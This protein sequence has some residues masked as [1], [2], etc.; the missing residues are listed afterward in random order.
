[1]MAISWFALKGFNK[2]NVAEEWYDELETTRKW[3]LNY[4]FWY[5]DQAAS[6]MTANNFPSKIYCEPPFKNET[7]V[8]CL[9]QI[10]DI[11]SIFVW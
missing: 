6:L 1:M 8:Q 3:G 7:Y 4:H 10:P 5:G 11:S 9:H 2:P